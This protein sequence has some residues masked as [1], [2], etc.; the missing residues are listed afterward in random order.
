MPVAINFAKR[1][2]WRKAVDR[3]DPADNIVTSSVL[4]LWITGSRR[5][6]CILSPSSTWYNVSSHTLGGAVKLATFSAQCRKIYFAAQLGYV[7]LIMTT[8]FSDTIETA[9]FYLIF[10]FIMLIFYLILCLYALY[11][12]S[13]SHVL[14]TIRLASCGNFVWI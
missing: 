1:S 2:V 12:S 7:L 6:V 11:L 13:L 10:R 4:W 8:W 3:S 14:H 5:V 9:W